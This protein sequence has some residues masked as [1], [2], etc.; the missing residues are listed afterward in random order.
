MIEFQ[1]SKL[2][3]VSGG[4]EHYCTQSGLSVLS[5]SREFM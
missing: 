2:I 5:Y 4:S 1:I 3:V